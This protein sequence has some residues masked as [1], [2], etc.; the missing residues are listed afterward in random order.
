[1][2]VCVSTSIKKRDKE[3]KRRRE[4]EKKRGTNLDIVDTVVAQTTVH[5]MILR[6]HA[7]AHAGARAGPG[8]MTR[9]MRV[10]VVRVVMMVARHCA[11]AR[12]AAV[13]EEKR[14]DHVSTLAGRLA[15]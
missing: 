15:A 9:I 2:P 3:K 5:Y 11:R 1:M 4:E 7:H 8:G 13:K 14:R 10:V 6:T 12:A